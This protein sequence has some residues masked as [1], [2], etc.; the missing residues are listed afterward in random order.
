LWPSSY[1]LGIGIERLRTTMKN[2]GEFSR[3]RFEPRSPK[4]E[5]VNRPTTAFGNV[6]YDPSVHIFSLLM[7]EM[8]PI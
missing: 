8:V 4:Y 2:L 5:V 3:L 1:C 7:K 6:L